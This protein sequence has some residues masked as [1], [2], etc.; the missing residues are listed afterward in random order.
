MPPFHKIL[1]G[2]IPLATI[3]SLSS[4]TRVPL[5]IFPTKTLTVAGYCFC[6]LVLPLDCD[7]GF[8]S[9][10]V[11]VLFESPLL[12]VVFGCFLLFF[13]GIASP[14][15]LSSFGISLAGFFLPFKSFFFAFLP[16][17]ALVSSEFLKIR[18]LWFYKK[19][20]FKCMHKRFFKDGKKNIL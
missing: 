10:F 11:F 2:L 1:T 8:S 15:G 12:V 14:F 20:N 5:G 13:G 3:T 18:Y 7:S 9:L 17:L 4:L 6:F 16:T 19:C